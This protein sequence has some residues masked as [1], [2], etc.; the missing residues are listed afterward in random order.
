MIQQNVKIYSHF[1]STFSI[2]SV[3]TQTQ[4]QRMTLSELILCINL[5]VAI[6]TMLNFDSDTNTDVKC[7]QALTVQTWDEV[8]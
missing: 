4:I 2:E 5:C 1:T 8:G 6:G 3:V 7:E